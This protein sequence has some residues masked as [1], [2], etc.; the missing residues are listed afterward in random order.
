MVSDGLTLRVGLPPLVFQKA[1]VTDTENCHW[2]IGSR[3]PW[4]SWGR[5]G[6]RV[7]EVPFP[8]GDARGLPAVGVPVSFFLFAGRPETGTKHPCLV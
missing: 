6:V 1:A 3:Y 2:P 5:G 7:P 4:A 8:A